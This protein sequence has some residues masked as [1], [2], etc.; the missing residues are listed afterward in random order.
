[1]KQILRISGRLGATLALACSATL[2]ATVALVAPGISNVPASAVT[3]P[4]TAAN[5]TVWAPYAGSGTAG[6]TYYVLEFSNIGTTTCTLHGFARV[7]G[8]TVGGALVG[9]PA[10]HEGTPALVTLAPR[11]T[12]HA[13][14]GVTD[15]GA[16]CGTSGVQAA[17]LRVVPPGQTLPAS[18]G[19]RDEVEHFP[20]EVC[21]NESSMHVQ[22]IR[23]GTGIPLYTTS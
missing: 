1:M 4:C 5:T 23:A 20:L 2:V 14:L 22:P 21:S 3:P 10:S 16:L 11:Q 6:T 19:E 18:P 9:K 13:I 17:G 15:T 7:W 8:V 12:A